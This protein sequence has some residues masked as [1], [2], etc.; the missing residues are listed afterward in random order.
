MEISQKIRDL[1]AGG[2]CETLATT[3]PCFGSMLEVLGLRSLLVAQSD[4]HVLGLI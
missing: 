3:Q 1:E 2:P 4:I